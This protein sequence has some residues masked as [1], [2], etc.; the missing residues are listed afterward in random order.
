MTFFQ[1]HLHLHLDEMK[2]WQCFF[3]LMLDV[4]HQTMKS[5]FVCML[6]FAD[7]F[8]SPRLINEKT[9]SVQMTTFFLYLGDMNS[10]HLANMN[11][12][13]TFVTRVKIA[14]SGHYCF[15]F[16]AEFYGQILFSLLFTYFTFISL[17][18]VCII[19]PFRSYLSTTCHPQ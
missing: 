3:I 8:S 15:L 4:L 6:F 14:T 11:K 10:V 9:S 7:V 12:Y 18:I 13:F 16:A 17:W 5:I 1:Y 19:F 2:L